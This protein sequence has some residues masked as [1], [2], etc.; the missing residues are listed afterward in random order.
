MDVI[1]Q[2]IVKLYYENIYFTKIFFCLPFL[3]AIETVSAVNNQLISRS[4][5]L[6]ANFL[7]GLK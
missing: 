7:L 1:T 3:I 4:S 5:D 2:K 6:G